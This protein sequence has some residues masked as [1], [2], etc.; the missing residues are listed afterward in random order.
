MHVCVCVCVRERE[1]E[2]ERVRMDHVPS[3][4]LKW[5]HENLTPAM[6]RK[7]WNENMG[8]LE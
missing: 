1:R 4:L 5:E 2:R 8:F 3:S 6:G 7:E